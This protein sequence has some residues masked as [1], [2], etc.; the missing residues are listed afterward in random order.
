MMIAIDETT[1]ESKRLTRIT[2]TDRLV[3]LSAIKAATM[4]KL[5]P[6]VT[7]TI[8]K[9]SALSCPTDGTKGASELFVEELSIVAILFYPDPPALGYVQLPTLSN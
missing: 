1:P 4:R 2:R 3:F 8:I 9:N 5:N 6:V 7:R